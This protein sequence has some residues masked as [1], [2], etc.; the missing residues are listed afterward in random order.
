[1][2]ETLR[3]IKTDG[4]SVG[5]F[6]ISHIGGHRYAVSFLRLSC[7]SGAS[8]QAEAGAR[9]LGSGLTV[10]TNRPP[11]RTGQRHPL[12]PE[13]S[14]RLV[15]TRHPRRRRCHRTSSARS[16]KLPVPG[17]CTDRPRFPVQVDRTIMQGKIIPELLRGGL[18]LAGKDG[19]RGVLDW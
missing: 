9:K 17:K 10:L 8:G 18:G 16:D 4:G 5:L 3:G 1:M 14:L 12:L 2:Q 15:R 6:K 13:R 11:R 19:P 7:L